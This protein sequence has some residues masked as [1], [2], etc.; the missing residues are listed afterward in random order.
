MCSIWWEKQ[1][2]CVSYFHFITFE[3]WSGYEWYICSSPS[4]SFSAT[5]KK[6][7]KSQLSH[8]Y[9]EKKI[10]FLIRSHCLGATQ[11]KNFLIF[12]FTFPEFSG[13]LLLRRRSH[14]RAREKKEKKKMRNWTNL[15]TMAWARKVNN[16]LSKVSVCWLVLFGNM[17][18]IV[19][20][21][22]IRSTIWSAHIF[23]LEPN[24]QVR[25][26]LSWSIYFVIFMWFYPHV[27]LS[28]NE[29]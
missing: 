13:S 21:I 12:L 24:I 22:W 9:G 11:E 1:Q 5:T 18:F 29:P 23:F 25:L 6:H 19:H 4:D 14:N 8:I 26:C 16:K 3:G 28:K 7:T 15:N 10:F 20:K 2:K 27:Y 17:V